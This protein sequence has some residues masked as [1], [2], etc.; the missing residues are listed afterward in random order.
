MGPRWPQDGPKRAPKTLQ[1]VYH[2]V[3]SPKISPK[4]PKMAQDEPKI[5]RERLK[6]AQNGPKLALLDSKL[7]QDGPKQA[8]T[9]LP[10]NLKM[11]LSPRRRA[12][13]VKLACHALFHHAASLSFFQRLKMT[14]A[15]PRLAQVGPK[16]APRW[17][18]DGLKMAPRWPQELPRKPNM[19]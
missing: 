15:G 17:A 8:S 6:M 18:Q 2:G 19:A 5:T 3:S 14:H 13:F 4:R 16:L 12:N 11:V 7:P 1:K 9:W 10:G